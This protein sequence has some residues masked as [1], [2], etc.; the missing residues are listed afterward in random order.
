MTNPRCCRCAAGAVYSRGGVAEVGAPLAM[1]D[2]AGLVGCEGL[3]VRAR[4]DEQ[5]YT[6]VLRTAGGA[7]YTARFTTRPGYNTLRLPFNTFRPANQEDPPLQPG[8]RAPAGA[9]IC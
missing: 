5:S 9:L 4:A 7:A 6:C 3:L 8:A 2:A 1:P